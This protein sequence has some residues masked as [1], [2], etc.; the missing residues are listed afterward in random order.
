MD[1]SLSQSHKNLKAV[2][3][4]SL[5]P[6]FKFSLFIP[7]IFVDCLLYARSGPGPLRVAINRVVL[8]L[9]ELEIEAKK[10]ER[11]EEQRKIINN[12]TDIGWPFT[13]HDVIL[14]RGRCV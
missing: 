7:K 13:G 3:L 11:K 8:A 4:I 6:H 9:L 2:K 5:I 10:G 14:M 12:P 1:L